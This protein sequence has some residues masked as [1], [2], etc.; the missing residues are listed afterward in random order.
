[1]ACDH[2]FRSERQAWC[3]LEHSGR[4]P[5]RWRISLKKAN[6]K[7]TFFLD[8]RKGNT[9]M[10]LQPLD[11]SILIAHADRIEAQHPMS[12]RFCR[13]LAEGGRL[14]RSEV[15]CLIRH[16]KYLRS[17]AFAGSVA[18]LIEELL[19]PDNANL[20]SLSQESQAVQV[21]FYCRC[22]HDESSHL[23]YEKILLL[24]NGKDVGNCCACWRCQNALT[25]NRS[26]LTLAL[27]EIGSTIL[28]PI[29]LY[30]FEAHPGCAR[31]AEL[32]AANSAEFQRSGET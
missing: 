12:A 25:D 23:G 20:S 30:R 27:C 7:R 4:N 6:D 29:Q 2:V 24:L 10:S 21:P 15:D 17:H 26:V 31:C 8:F 18:N 22:G 14:L 16:V 9:P 5:T 3:Q 11:T 32:A 13:M 19:G 1:M 28:R